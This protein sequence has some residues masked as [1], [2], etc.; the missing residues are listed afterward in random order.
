MDYIEILGIAAAAIILISALFKNMLCLRLI[1]LAGSALFCVYGVL[2]GA[3][4]VWILNGGLIIIQIYQIIR[5]FKER[6][7]YNKVVCMTLN[8]ELVGDMLDMVEDLL[9]EKDITIPSDDRE[10]G[11]DEARLFGMEHA[12]LLDG[13]ENLLNRYYPQGAVDNSDNQKTGNTVFDKCKIKYKRK[14]YDIKSDGE[15]EKYTGGLWD[16]AGTFADDI[17]NQLDGNV[18]FSDDLD[19][20][21]LIIQERV[22]NLIKYTV[23]ES[24]EKQLVKQ[25]QSEM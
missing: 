18:H 24:L 6:K 2:T 4:S 22:Y 15:D 3:L 23:L 9:D 21:Y 17:C 10:G 13:F 16:L 12:R 5:L 8:R 25:N 7:K 11:E 1:N 14:D 19:G 20:A